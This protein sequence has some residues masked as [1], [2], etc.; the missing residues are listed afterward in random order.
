MDTEKHV[1][2]PP[3]PVGIYPLVRPAEDPLNPYKKSM[4][5]SNPYIDKSM[6]VYMYISIEV[7]M[8]VY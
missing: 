8:Y 5:M 1:T 7:S 6:Y 4:Y 3:P 2:V